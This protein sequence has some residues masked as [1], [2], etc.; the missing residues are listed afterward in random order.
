MAIKNIG[1]K[2]HELNKAIKMI[3]INTEEVLYF[4]SKFQTARWLTEY[5]ILNNLLSC[6][7]EIGPC[8]VYLAIQKNRIYKN[9]FKFEYAENCD[10]V[11]MTIIKKMKPKLRCNL[12]NVKQNN[13][14][15]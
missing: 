5:Y 12:K 6:D 9:Q 14:E 13:I 11:K 7:K 2:A 10:D 3:D 4:P 8:I 15:N 1:H